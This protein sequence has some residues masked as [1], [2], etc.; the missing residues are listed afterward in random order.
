[1]HFVQSA[2]N[3]H[4]EEHSFVHVT[5]DTILFRNLHCYYCLTVCEYCFMMKMKH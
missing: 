3:N 4:F 2:H 5:N 1:M